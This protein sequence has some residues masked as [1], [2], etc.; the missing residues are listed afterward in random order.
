MKSDI[1]MIDNQGKGFSD[2]VKETQRVARYAG[3]D[4]KNTLHLQLL[5]EEMLSLCRSVTG[6]MKASFWLESDRGTYT[7]HMNTN[8]VLDSIERQELIDSTTNRRN[9]ATKSFLGMVRDAFE[10]AMASDKT[11]QS[12]EFSREEAEDMVGRDMEVPEWDGYERS[13]LAKLA[14]DVK[15]SIK[16]QE[17]DMTVSK[18]FA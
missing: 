16:G 7:L 5:T 13:V 6:E 10:R 3:L 12:Y 1:I 2:A 18:S 4:R 15:V 14:D 8:T 9:E 11:Y 17:V